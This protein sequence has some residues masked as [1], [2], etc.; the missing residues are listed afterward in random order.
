MTVGDYK[1]Q[2]TREIVNDAISQLCN[3][4]FA[5]D[6]AASFLVLQSMIRI[7]DRQMRKDAA[8]MAAREAED[9]VD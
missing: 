2:K 4:G 1:T 9:T 7:E 3:M 6:H 8:A 5:P